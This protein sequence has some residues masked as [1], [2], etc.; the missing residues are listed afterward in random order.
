MNTRVSLSELAVVGSEGATDILFCTAKRCCGG[1]YDGGLEVKCGVP[2]G[3]STSKSDILDMG[4]R[5]GKPVGG[6][7]LP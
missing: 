2:I 7:M 1:P 3:N 6:T 5:P 4:E